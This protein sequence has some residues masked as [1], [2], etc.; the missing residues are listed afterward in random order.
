MNLEFKSY[1]EIK[2]FFTRSCKNSDPCEVIL[3]HDQRNTVHQLLNEVAA[4]TGRILIDKD[5]STIEPNELGGMKLENKV[6]SWMKEAMDPNSKTGHIIY[7]REYHLA[8][9]KVQNDV[10]NILIKKDIEGIKFP[11]KTLIILG[12]RKE[13]ETAAGL[14]HTHIIKF[15]K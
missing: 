12:V 3:F 5:L 13:D 9:E 2:K 4:E 11:K 1:D 15:F 14:T 7:L 8:P 6:P 10:L